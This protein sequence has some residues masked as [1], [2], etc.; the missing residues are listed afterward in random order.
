MR[1]KYLVI[2]ILIIPVISLFLFIVFAL[3]LSE[4]L[5][6]K[7][8]NLSN[9][10]EISVILE[11]S[12]LVFRDREIKANIKIETE[13]KSMTFEGSWEKDEF[14]ILL[15]RFDNQIYWIIVDGYCETWVNNMQSNRTD[16]EFHSSFF[17][18]IKQ[19]D[20]LYQIKYSNGT[21]KIINRL[22]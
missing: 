11:E 15:L 5:L 8:Y 20:T 22:R 16:F 1:S 21:E 19:I 17:D 7:K 18:S 3:L 14:E 2:T 9:G 4:T 12:R 6:K 13:K 10:N